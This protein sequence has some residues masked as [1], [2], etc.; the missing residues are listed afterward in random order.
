MKLNKEQI[1][2]LMNL[3]KEREESIYLGTHLAPS[4]LTPSAYYHCWGLS[5]WDGNWFLRRYSYGAASAESQI[6]TDDEVRNLLS[7]GWIYRDA[8]TVAAFSRFSPI[9]E[10]V[11][12]VI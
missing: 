1:D 10:L 6:L 11:A 3:L 7:R 8:P 5:F 4:G 12:E 2:A 9:S